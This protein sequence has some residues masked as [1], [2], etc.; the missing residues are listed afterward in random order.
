M[1]SFQR[2]GNI[3]LFSIYLIYDCV[4]SVKDIKNNNLY[5]NANVHMCTI[6]GKKIL[7]TFPP[8]YLVPRYY[9]LLLLLC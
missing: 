6:I 7:Y 3:L 5:S 8:F 4:K 1:I 2:R 9:A